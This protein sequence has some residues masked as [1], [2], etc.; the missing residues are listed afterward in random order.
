MK[1]G[2]PDLKHVDSRICCMTKSERA[3]CSMVELNVRAMTTKAL[4]EMW[5]LSFDTAI[6]TGENVWRTIRDIYCTE[7]DRRDIIVYRRDS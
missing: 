7:L 5:R 6:D 2:T 4:L 3:M 1:H